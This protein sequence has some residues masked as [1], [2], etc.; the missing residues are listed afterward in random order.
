MKPY[1]S[2]TLRP[3][4]S[5]LYSER[6]A[7]EFGIQVLPA[8]EVCTCHGEPVIDRRTALEGWWDDRCRREN[9][10]KVVNVHPLIRDIFTQHFGI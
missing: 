2:L 10:K 8:Q 9:R 3:C 1:C 4:E 6:I 7:D 5:T